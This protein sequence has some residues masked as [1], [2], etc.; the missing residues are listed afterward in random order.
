MERLGIGP[1]VCLAAQPATGLRADDRVGAIGPVCRCRRPRHQLHLAGRR[2][3]PL[4][5]RRRKHRCRRSTWSATSAGAACCWPSVWCAR[6]WRRSAAGTGQVVDAAMVD[7][8]AVLM[9]MFWSFRKIGVFDEDAPRHQPARHRRALLRR[10]SMRRRHVH[11][12]RFDRAAVLC[13]AA[14]S[15][16]ARPTTRRSPSRWTS[17][18]G[19]T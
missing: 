13:R 9:S 16:R 5:T 4:R 3:R 14:A 12:D 6:C 11:L 2:A 10:L 19:R 8:A 18:P 17:R 1:D 15:D 7:G